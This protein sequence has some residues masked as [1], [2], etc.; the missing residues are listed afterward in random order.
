[1]AKSKPASGTSSYRSTFLAVGLVAAAGTIAWFGY[2]PSGPGGAAEEVAGETVTLEA[3]AMAAASAD[4]ATSE[5]SG[6][7]TRVRVETAG[8]DTAVQEVGVVRSSG[9]ATWETAWRAAGHH[10]NS[11]IPGNPGNVV[12]SGHVS[13]VS[14]ANTPVFANLDAV[15]IGD[16]V[17]VFSGAVVHRY[18]VTEKREVAPDAIDVLAADHRSLVTLITCTRDLER[19]LV[20]V[21]EL[22]S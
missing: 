2:R 9:R 19:R 8:I 6:L 17:E 4:G 1:V 5:R 3:P 10:I 14:A 15:R 7:P 12:L 20:V 18:Q 22:V 16:I 21:G 11:S 13:V